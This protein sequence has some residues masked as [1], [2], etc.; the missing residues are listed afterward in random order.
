MA[1]EN[2][3]LRTFE[4]TTSALDSN[5]EITLQLDVVKRHCKIVRVMVAH[6][7]GATAATFQPA[8]GNVATFTTDT[9]D[10]KYLASS[11]AIADLLDDTALEAYT[12]TDSGGALYFRP[13][14]NAGSDNVFDYAISILVW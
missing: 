11:T 12:S 14:P 13:A 4:G 2:P 3:M 5:D 8:I 10:E 7:T 9:V 1:A 6:T